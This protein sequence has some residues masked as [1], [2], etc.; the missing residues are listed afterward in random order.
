LTPNVALHLLSSSKQANPPEDDNIDP[1]L[2]SC[3]PELIEKIEM[4]IVD[5][6]DPVTFDDI[7]TDNSWTELAQM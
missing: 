1:R 4:E 3:D 2:K 7:G 6:G 5:S